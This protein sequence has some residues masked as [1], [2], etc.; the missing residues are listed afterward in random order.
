MRTGFW[1]RRLR[2][3]VNW[4]ELG[5]D[6]RTILKCVFSRCDGRSGLRWSGSGQGQVAAFCEYGNEPSVSITCGEFLE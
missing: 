6:Q 3:R 1:W 2:E 4:E 5:V